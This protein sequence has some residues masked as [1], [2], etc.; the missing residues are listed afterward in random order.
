LPVSGTTQVNQ[1]LVLCHILS[2]GYAQHPMSRCKEE[3]GDLQS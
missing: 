1:Q 2:L 3:T